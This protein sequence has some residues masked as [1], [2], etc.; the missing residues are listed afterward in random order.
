M[1]KSTDHD[2]IMV[3][4]SEIAIPIDSVDKYKFNSD[5]A[6]KIHSYVHAAFYDVVGRAH[7]I[8]YSYREED[9]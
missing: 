7:I 3:L 5:K 9:K 6:K 4:I 1:T 8:W 2:K